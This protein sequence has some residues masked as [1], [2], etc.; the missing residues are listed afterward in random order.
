M[1]KQVLAQIKEE[2]E[3]GLPLF[4]IMYNMSLLDTTPMEVRLELIQEY[5]PPIRDRLQENAKNAVKAKGLD[6]DKAEG[7]QRRNPMNKT[8]LNMLLPRVTKLIELL[9]PTEDQPIIKQCLTDVRD[10][11]VT[12][13]SKTRG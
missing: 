11:L 12:L 5:G 13:E 1:D 7:T 10:L 2:L 3:K 9:D 6:P 8:S 4:K